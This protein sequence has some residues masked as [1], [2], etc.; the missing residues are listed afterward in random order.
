[1]KNELIELCVRKAGKGQIYGNFLPRGFNL[2]SCMISK[3][4]G[5]GLRKQM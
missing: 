4:R 5:E 3:V 2:A 1:M